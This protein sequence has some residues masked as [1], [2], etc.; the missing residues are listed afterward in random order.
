VKLTGWWHVVRND[1]RPLRERWRDYW[2][3]RRYMKG[4]GRPP[5]REEAE[6]IWEYART[7]RPTPLRPDPLLAE[8]TRRAEAG[9]CDGVWHVTWPRESACPKCGET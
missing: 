9:L 7:M 1:P 2:G 6:R 8:L 4:P 5:T 3:A